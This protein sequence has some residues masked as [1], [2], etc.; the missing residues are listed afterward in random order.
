MSHNRQEYPP[1]RN[2]IDPG[3]GSLD[4]YYGDHA[5]GMIFDFNFGKHNGR[6][7][8][9]LCLNYLAWWYTTRTASGRSHPTLS[10]IE[11]YVD[12]LREYAKDNYLDFVVP[13]G[14][15]HGGQTIGEC[16]DK[17]WMVWSCTKPDLIIKHPIYFLAVDYHLKNP[18]H[19]NQT[20]DIGE[21]LSATKYADDKDLQHEEEEDESDLSDIVVPDGY[22]EYESDAESDSDS[23]EGC[24][25][26]VEVTSPKGKKQL[27]S[28]VQGKEPPKSPSKKTPK[29]IIIS[30]HQNME[31]CTNFINRDSFDGFL[32]DDSSHDGDASFQSSSTETESREDSS[33]ESLSAEIDSEAASTISSVDKSRQNR[34]RTS[35]QAT[36]IPHRLQRPKGRIILVKCNGNRTIEIL[37]AVTC[38]FQNPPI[39]NYVAQKMDRLGRRDPGSGK[40]LSLTPSSEFDGVEAE[41]G[42]EGDHRETDSGAASTVNTTPE[43]DSDKSA[44]EEDSGYA[45][46][47]QKD[48]RTKQSRKVQIHSNNRDVFDGDVRIPESSPSKL[49]RAKVVV[50]SEDE[51]PPRARLW[52]RRGLNESD[53]D[54]FEENVQSP[55]P[56]V[57]VTPHRRVVS[58]DEDEADLTCTKSHREKPFIFSQV[59]TLQGG[60]CAAW[61]LFSLALL[62]PHS[63]H[64]HPNM[65]CAI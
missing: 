9:A 39:L 60:I 23:D 29:N 15:K 5:G 1:L 57:L 59:Q 24:R 52:K 45:T 25:K 38:R 4:W 46:P 11:L 18:R 51:P 22:V 43:L 44:S 3:G 49:R 20:R 16:R 7:L 61:I 63:Q 32:V 53:E 64:L 35:L 40:V 8:H 27:S 30:S 13:F 33:S 14:Q 36:V 12:G 42:S 19:Y 41:A 55:G 37:S 54:D 6:K 47:I 21:L 10:A 34:T 50:D 56:C 48:R 58:D 28:D 26:G 17:K 31:S 2:P 62:I 65:D